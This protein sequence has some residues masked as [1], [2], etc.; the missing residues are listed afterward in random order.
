MEKGAVIWWVIILVVIIII[1][2]SFFNYAKTR[3][4]KPFT[5]DDNNCKHYQKSCVCV[6]LVYIL[7]TYPE[8][9]NCKGFELCKNIDEKV[10]N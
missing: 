8:Q 2:M 6:G 1:G 9:Y 10:C 3:V 5:L 7:E 4:Y